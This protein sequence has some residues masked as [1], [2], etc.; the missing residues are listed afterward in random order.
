MVDDHLI[1]RED[2][3]F[4]GLI[5]DRRISYAA[6]NNLNNASMF[7]VKSS[8]FCTVI[9]FDLYIKS[10]SWGLATFI[11]QFHNFD[12]MEDTMARLLLYGVNN[13]GEILEGSAL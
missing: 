7:W 8:R 4:M 9:A 3:A 6:S 1:S 2:W 13:K 10:A 11:G 12:K 5:E